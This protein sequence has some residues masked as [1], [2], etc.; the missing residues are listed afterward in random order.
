[1]ADLGDGDHVDGVVELAVATRVEAVPDDGTAG[2]F[3]RSGGVVAG[4]VP[5]ARE[6]GDVT[7][8][9]DEIGGDDRPNPVD[10]GE[11]GR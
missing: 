6:P 11:R 4:V 2:G 9:A 10:L 8:V 5:G 3:D 1:V 7:A